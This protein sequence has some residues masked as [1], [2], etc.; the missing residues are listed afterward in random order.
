[1]DYI[2]WI[3]ENEPKI[4]DISQQ[5]YSRFTYEP[6]IS[7]VIPV[8]NISLNI[9]T[10]CLMSV[11]SQSYTNWELCIADASDDKIVEKNIQKTTK[12]KIK[13]IINKNIADNTN[14]ALSLVTGEYVVFLDHDDALAPFALYEIVKK[15]ND[16]PCSDVIYSDEDKIIEGDTSNP[17]GTTSKKLY[18]INPHFKPDWSPDTLRS[19]NYICH[20]FCLKKELLDK[21]GGMNPEY[22]G[23][24]DYD[25]ILRATEQAECIEHIPMILYH[26][27]MTDG[28]TALKT[29]NKMYAFVSAK[30]ALR[31]HLKRIGYSGDVQ[32][33]LFLS[34]YKILYNMKD[35]PLVS[36]IIPNCN[37]LPI[38]KECIDSIIRAT[39]YPN[40]EI[41]IIENNS[42][43]QNVFEYYKELK[44]RKFYRGKEKLEK[45][46]IVEWNNPFNY[47][48]INNFGVEHAKG[49][50]IL[51]LNNDTCIING[52]WLTR[53]MEYIVRE[54]VGVVGAKLYFANN[55]IQHAG[56]VLGLGKHGMPGHIY[57]KAP[58]NALGYM[59]RLKI[60]QN[61]T[62]VTG[63]CLLTKKSVF[64]DVGG[65]DEKLALAFND[66]DYCYKVLTKGYRIVWTPYAELYHYE[67]LS[68][69]YENTKEKVDRFWEEFDYLLNRWKGLINGGDKLFPK[70]GWRIKWQNIQ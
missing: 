49:E 30:K 61:L 56:V 23:S 17:D 26:W 70:N 37:S 15:I 32:D 12:V 45:F 19:Y 43:D 21:I 52:D 24:Q 10:D 68:R 47:S 39:S 9:L 58:K 25:L 7:V 31:E 60:V 5:H 64:K 53:M 35:K 16:N 63:A 55:T 40:Y 36:I 4:E 51:L 28:S 57:C 66:I 69:G 42:T 3:N 44:N 67:S 18:R 14:E 59:G 65:L 50:Y 6:K 2:E 33:G 13:N 27:R 62:A 41:V 29:E 46:K 20:L 48:K 8:Y 34:S 11:L 1:M 38:L 54:D 22:N